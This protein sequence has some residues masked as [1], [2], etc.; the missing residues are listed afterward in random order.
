[1]L[2]IANSYIEIIKE[3][4]RASYPHECCGILLGTK[5]NAEKSVT[6][7]I[8]AKNLNVER[9]A[10]RYLLDPKDQL[11]AE[12]EARASGQQV[13]GFYHS[14]PDHPALPSDTDNELS[15]PDYSYM[16]LSVSAQGVG[17]INCY[18]RSER[19]LFGAKSKPA[20]I[21]EE[22]EIN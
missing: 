1:M 19:F 18:S 15:W 22:L 6:R 14:H 11:A 13:L 12:K 20:L 3:H 9:A 8:P 4:A 10:D 21:F 7:A 2:R 17:D 5:L 16:I